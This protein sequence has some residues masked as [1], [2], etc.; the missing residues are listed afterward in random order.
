MLTVQD[1]NLD[2]DGSG[3]QNF[4]YGVLQQLE[5]A[6]FISQLKQ[7]PNNTSLV[8]F[9]YSS[10]RIKKMLISAGE[11]LEVYA[12]YD[13]LKTGY[14]DDVAS[15]YEFSWESGGVKNEL[16]LVLTKGFRSMIVEC[17]A[18]VEL[19]LDYY[20][21]LH[22]ISDQFGIGTIKVLIGNTYARFD[23]VVNELNTMQRSRGNQLGIKTIS[24]RNQIVNIGHTLM[25]MMEEAC[26]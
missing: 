13:V 12:Y 8:S 9:V 23:A 7:N 17:K 26:R 21:K 16:D 11:I 14:F 2:L 5:K 3:R 20:H 6:H 10:P 19:K 24:G 18:V 22:S 1:V 4:P 15:G 25:Q